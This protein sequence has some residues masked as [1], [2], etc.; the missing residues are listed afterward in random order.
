M[1]N[2]KTKWTLEF[3][4]PFDGKPTRMKGN[5][6]VKASVEGVH[7]ITAADKEAFLANTPY[8]LLEE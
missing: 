7:F 8:Y 6:S 1:A 5:T 4:D 2:D 3:N